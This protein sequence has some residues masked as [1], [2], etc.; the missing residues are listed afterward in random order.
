MAETDL[1]ALFRD[2]RVNGTAAWL[3][4]ALVALVGVLAVLRGDPLWGGFAVG[5]ALLAIAPALRFRDPD[6]MP[7]WEVLLLVALPAFG[8][9]L[10]SG[11]SGTLFTYLAV[12]GVALIVA[13]EL[14][15]FSPISMTIGF[16]ILLTVVATMATAGVWGLVRGAGEWYLG[17]DTLPGNKEL[18]WEFVYSVVAG[19]A[20]GLVFEY[21]FRRTSGATERVPESVREEIDTERADETERRAA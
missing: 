3:L 20:A 14:H 6:V 7:P 11:L 18:N 8:R 15:A 2:T 9:A 12:A 19:L 4:T 17:M 5:A 1:D 10:V 16:A 13:V 21:Y